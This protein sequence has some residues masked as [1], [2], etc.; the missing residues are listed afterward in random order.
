MLHIE[1]IWTPEIQQIHFRLLLEVMSRPGKRSELIEIPESGKPFLS[2]LSALLDSEVSLSDPDNLLSD[3]DWLMLQA[4]RSEPESADYILCSASNVPTF[5]PKLGTL[6][7]PEKSATIVLVASSLEQGSL[8]LRLSGP[9]IAIDN[10]LVLD[11]V[12]QEWLEKRIDWNCAFPLGVDFIL[13][14]SRRVT[15]I[16]RTTKV[17]IL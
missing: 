9:G 11:G 5:T 16:P 6:P 12:K 7:S 17:E 3:D 14:D 13:L 4:N 8:T 2:V 15:A 1:P 10:E